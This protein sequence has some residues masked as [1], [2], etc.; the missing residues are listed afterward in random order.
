MHRIVSSI[1][2][3]AQHIETLA[4]SPQSY[5]LPTCPRCGLGVPRIHGSYDRKVDRKAGLGLGCRVVQVPRFFCRGCERTHSRLPLCIAPRRWYD[6][7]VQQILLAL[8][9]AGVSVRACAQRVGVDRHTVRRWRNWL[10]APQAVEF[11]F[12]LRSRWPELGRLPDDPSLWRQVL[13]CPGLAPAMAF[14]DT[15]MDVP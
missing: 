6:W 10:L 11:V 13:V 2:T 9:L 5:R 8:V 3:L 14:V 15:R 7:A 12:H 4:S 1:T